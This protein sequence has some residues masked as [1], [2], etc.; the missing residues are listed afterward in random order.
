MTDSIEAKVSPS[1]SSPHLLFFPFPAS[2]H[3]IPLLEL[4][5]RL[6]TRGFTITVLVTPPNLHLLDPLLSSSLQTLV[7]TP[8]QLTSKFLLIGKVRSLSELS[9]PIL[10]WFRSHPSPPQAIVSDFFLGWTQKIASELGI[11]RLAFCPSGAFGTAVFYTL[12]RDTPNNPDPDNLKSEIRFDGIPNSPAYP[13]WH[14]SY[15]YRG[16]KGAGPEEAAAWEFFRECVVANFASWGTIIN[17]FTDLERVYIDY[18][19]KE[20]GHDRVW[21]VGPML[22]PENDLASAT[23]RGGPNSVPAEEVL[24]W[25]DQRPD[26]SVVY[27][28]FGSRTS[29]SAD[30]TAALGTALEDSG[31][32][33]IWAFRESDRGDA[34]SIPEGFEDRVAGKGLVIRGWA[35]QLAI[36]RHRA[37][38]SFLT[39][40]GWNSVLESLA[41]G[42]MMVAW[43][44]GADQFTDAKLVEEVGAAMSVKC[45]G[46]ENVPDS[47]ELARLLRESVSGNRPERER[48]KELRVAAAEAVKEGGSSRKNLEQ[49]VSELIRLKD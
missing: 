7:L 32:D 14:V 20:M 25:L 15:I 31:V 3:I 33:F 9:A 2:G 23:K 46:P 24:T 35:P 22:P 6:L 41:A 44:M 19:K 49:L 27:I 48:V 38:A 30:Q 17:T 11:Q 21:A 34:G 18:L 8:P 4:A 29:L 16:L 43:P 13:W 12:W 47:R 45:E 37:T 40:C 28:C 1:S 5:Q 10:S 42:V 26:C 39:H 36:L